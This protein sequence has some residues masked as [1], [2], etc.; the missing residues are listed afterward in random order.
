MPVT[1]RADSGKLI[2]GFVDLVYREEAG[3]VVVDFKTD[4]ELD[5]AADRYQRQIRIY[6]A[7]LAAATGLS[8]RAVLMRV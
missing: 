6:T 3:M 8:A 4:R 1:M 7:A 5:R 2:E